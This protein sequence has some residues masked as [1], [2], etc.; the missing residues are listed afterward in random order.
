MHFIHKKTPKPS[1][2][3]RFVF[4]KKRFSQI[5]SFAMPLKLV[6]GALLGALGGAGIISVLSEYATYSFSIYHGFRPP[7]EGIPYLKAGVALASFSL[8][9]TGAIVFLLSV[10]LVK[11]A[12]WSFEYTFYPLIYTFNW[13]EK[14]REKVNKQYKYVFL[15]LSQRPL[16]QIILLSI[17]TGVV[18]GLIGYFENW[19]LFEKILNINIPIISELNLG[20]GVYIFI[21]TLALSNKR[22]IWWISGVATFLYFM[23]WIYILFNPLWYAE[24]LRTVGYGGGIPITLEIKD[25]I[26]QTQLQK[27]D[28]FLLLRTTEAVIYLETESNR[29]IE[30]PRDRVLSVS[31]DGGGLRRIGHKLP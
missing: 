15:R 25:P 4:F 27:I 24:F 31:H 20:F 30:I 13:G 18:G 16:W 26:N 12:L 11:V 7:L 14:R 28:G 23:A 6:L 21:L 5:I 10:L 17:A 8:L 2:H 19:L 3:T 1:A 29:I 22:I 9:L